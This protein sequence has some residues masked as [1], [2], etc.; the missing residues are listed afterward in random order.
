MYNPLKFL[1]NLFL[2]HNIEVTRRIYRYIY[3][4]ISEVLWSRLKCVSKSKLCFHRLQSIP[5]EFRKDILWQ[6]FN[7][8]TIVAHIKRSVVNNEV[9]GRT[10]VAI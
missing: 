4:N 5:N 7:Y 6:H 8:R 1:H 2:L 3:G 9:P 10:P